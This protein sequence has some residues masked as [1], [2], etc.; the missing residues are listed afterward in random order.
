MRSVLKAI[1]QN[2]PGSQTVAKIALF[3]TTTATAASA[4]SATGV[5]SSAGSPAAPK[6]Q[7]QQQSM[8]DQVT[9]PSIYIERSSCSL[10]VFESRNTQHAYSSRNIT[11][12][13]PEYK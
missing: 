4:A 8:L 5:T 2:L 7:Q 9:R 1:K 10:T 6:Q 3:P 13:K 12:L 11:E